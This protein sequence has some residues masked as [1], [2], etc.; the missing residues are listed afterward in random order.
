[1]AA[2]QGRPTP[3]AIHKAFREGWAKDIANPS[4]TNAHY[5][6]RMDF[7]QAKSLCG[8][9]SDV[10]WLHAPG[11][12]EKCDQCRRRLK[13]KLKQDHNNPTRGRA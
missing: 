2:Q 6:V 7:S 9:E 3:G 10:R 4:Q 13:V 8:L 1:M 11:S 5:Y 12:F